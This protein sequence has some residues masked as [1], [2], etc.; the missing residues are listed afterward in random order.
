VLDLLLVLDERGR[1]LE[2][3]RD[4][5]RAV[6]L[7]Q[8]ERLLRREKELLADRVIAYIAAG[9]LVGQPLADVALVGPGTLRE[10]RGG[11]RCAVGIAR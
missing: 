4:E 10:L 1:E 9:G 8:R 2:R 5:R 7:G 3:A 6:L 11:D